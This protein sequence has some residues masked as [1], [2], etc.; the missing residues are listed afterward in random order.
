MKF[1]HQ[2]YARE[3]LTQVNSIEEARAR[4]GAGSAYISAEDKFKIGDSCGSIAGRDAAAAPMRPRY[5]NSRDSREKLRTSR[6]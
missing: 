1:R 3:V 5:A 6:T 4:S 2:E